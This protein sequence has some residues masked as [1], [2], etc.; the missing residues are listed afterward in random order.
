MKRLLFIYILILCYGVCCAQSEFDKEFEEFKKQ[1]LCEFDDFKK[2]CNEEYI[3][4]L[5]KTWKEFNS[6]TP[7]PLPKDTLTVPP[8]IYEE[9]KPKEEIENKELLNKNIV[10]P[11]PPVTE[12]VPEE[13]IVA[14][15]PPIVEIE[16][17]EPIF[18]DDIWEKDKA[19]YSFSFYGTEASI[20]MGQE[21]SFKL[22]ACNNCNVASAWE[23][24]SNNYDDIVSEC[25]ELQKKHNL[26]DWG[27]LQM[28]KK[29]SEQFY[30]ART[31][32][33]TLMTSYIYCL[34][35]YKAKMGISNGRLYLLVACE[36]QIYGKRY[37]DINGEKFY[38][39]D[40]EE[41]GMK[42]CDAD[43]KGSKPLSL[44]INRTPNLEYANCD[45]TRQLKSKRY[46]NMAISVNVNKNLMDFYS[47]YPASEMGSDFMTKWV[48]YANNPLSNKIKE[49]IYPALKESLQG[50]EKLEQVNMLLNF[51]QTAFVYEYDEKV[52]GH[53]R[54]FFSE[55]T[56]YYKYCDCE[57]RSILFSRLV[58]DI[59]GLKV[60]L[61]YY[62]GHIATAVCIDEQ[63][64][65]DFVEMNNE[66]YTICDPTY[67]NAPVG[68]SMPELRDL[69]IT[70]TLLK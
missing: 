46:P 50:K 36:H 64:H 20:H 1:T 31:N 4:H 15:E 54:S 49:Q 5:K 47:D 19:T 24:C 18:I 62:P 40:C 12:P 56:L 60:M 53:D 28:I 41:D 52:W 3:E 55:E 14:P 42:I 16:P 35:G 10:T 29:M 30:G 21:H 26:C 66:K 37:F 58:R 2:K 33:A 67:I 68:T 9:E 23:F 17:E 13:S 65:G 61:V 57:D 27:Y 7:I 63:A 39:I 22:Q 8:V 69:N 48:V 25:L 32:E 43:F 45:T 70:L 59:L 34:S 6:L 11:E 38:P 51:V 44:W